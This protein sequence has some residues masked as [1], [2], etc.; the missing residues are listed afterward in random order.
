MCDERDGREGEG[1]GLFWRGWVTNISHSGCC[2]GTKVVLFASLLKYSTVN[3]PFRKS[4]ARELCFLTDFLQTIII[5]RGRALPGISSSEEV[6]SPVNPGNPVRELGSPH[7][8]R[9]EVKH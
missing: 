3:E 5:Q 2:S 1:P 7:A 6:S 8:E 4:P 9:W